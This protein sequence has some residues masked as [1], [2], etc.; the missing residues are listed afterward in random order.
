[1]KK[2]PSASNKGFRNPPPGVVEDLLA[3]SNQGK[4]QEL[5]ASSRGL[6][7]KYPNYLIGWLSLGKACMNLNRTEEAI[8]SF[9]RLVTLAPQHTECYLDLGYLYTLTGELDKAEN[10]CAKAL[11]L[12][13]QSSAALH[14]LATVYA[15]QK[16]ITDAVAAFEKAILLEPG[17]KRAR[18]DLGSLLLIQG[19]YAG[20]VIHLE[21]ALTLD[22]DFLEAW[23][24]LGMCCGHLAQFDKAEA[25]LLQAFRINPDSLIGLQALSRHYGQAGDLD[26]ALMYNLKLIELAP[27]DPSF[28]IDLGNVYLTRGEVEKSQAYF[29]ESRKIRPFTEFDNQSSQPEFTA[30]FLDTAGAGSTPMH[31]LTERS[32]FRHLVYC[33]LMAEDDHVDL[34]NQKADVVFNMIGD[35]DNG[36]AIL[37]R[38]QRIADQL[39]IPLLN[40][41][42]V[43]L[44]TNREKI[45]AKITGIPFTRTPHFVRMSGQEISEKIAAHADFGFS[46]PMLLRAAGTHGGSDFELHHGF[47]SVV[48][49]VARDLGKTY[50]LSEYIDSSAQDGMYRK[51]RIIYVAGTLFPYHLAIHDHWMVHYFRTNMGESPKHLQEEANF[52][53]DPLSVF[54]QDQWESLRAIGQAT[55]LDYCGI[56]CGFDCN[57]QIVIYEA[58]AT[59]LVHAESEPRFQFKNPYT[60]NIR[61]AFQ[62]MLANRK[63]ARLAV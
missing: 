34:I 19:D 12:N 31:Y 44:E 36:H 17:N 4:W 15:K 32:N 38:A 51:Y 41:P 49:Y 39:Q 20:A 56:D 2:I 58:N 50:Y 7:R 43:V 3:K 18:N 35:A 26:K 8:T 9:K 55:G 13:P 11:S 63:R 23:V 22:V 40:H 28:L 37:E 10:A 42:T 29:Y 24:N 59:M 57:G 45:A 21:H 60:E 48:D 1:M 54:S 52:L 33:V 61:L 27:Q 6:T 25:S 62:Q 53:R 47:A 46:L 16:R 14:S 30:V 5:A